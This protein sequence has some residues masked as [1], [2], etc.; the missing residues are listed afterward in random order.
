MTDQPSRRWPITAEIAGT[1]VLVATVVTVLAMIVA[2]IWLASTAIITIL[3]GV[4]LAVLFD[5]GARGLAYVV[6]W[7]RRVR[8]TVVFAVAT[9]LI[10]LALFFGGAILVGQA[11]N[12]VSAMKKLF[13]EA[14]QFLQNGG[15]GLFP[16]GTDLR[17][18]LP[19]G[20]VLFGG[21]TDIATTAMGIVVLLAAIL[22]LGAFFAWEPG[23]YKAVILSL[24][25]KD[26]RSRAS[27]VLDLSAH[28]MREWL[29]GQSVSMTVIFLASITSLM[30]VGMPYPALLAVQAGLLSFIPTVG[31]FV[32]GII[33]I[34]AGLSQ[35][36]VMA[37]YGL[38]TYLLIQFL[39]TH[40]VT[41]LV[42]ERTV[43]L[44]PAT[45]LGL[46]VIAGT[47]FGI[48]GIIFAVPIAAAGKTLV[49]EL[50]VKDYLGGP[51]EIPGEDTHSRIYRW[52]R[53]ILGDRGK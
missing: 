26:R 37:L 9:I 53:P 22:F 20:A 45:T 13:S 48:L 30:L 39:E 11:N 35:S 21:A 24:L 42:Q 15:L 10:V 1:T 14:N 32:A 47:L 23:V 29:I 40:L 19:G 2:V 38:G 41:P 36:F 4:L 43:R 27:E 8:L 16:P 25:P 49:E 3:A 46:Q 34:L 12:F 18:L 28:A 50:Y 44:P 33:I 6:P 17:S 52:I 7:G 31:P 51:W 5:A